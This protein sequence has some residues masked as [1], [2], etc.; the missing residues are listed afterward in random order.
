MFVYLFLDK[1]FDDIKTMG[2][3]ALED[4]TS[5]RPSVQVS[6]PVSLYCEISN[7]AVDGL[8]AWEQRPSAD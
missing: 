2:F 1:H 6:A 5:G 7:S 4:A 8:R 3:Q